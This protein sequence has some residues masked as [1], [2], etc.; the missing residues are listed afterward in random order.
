MLDVSDLKTFDNYSVENE[1]YDISKLGIIDSDE[2]FDQTLA[3]NAFEKL[4][5]IVSNL[6]HNDEI[7]TMMKLK[8]EG[9]LRICFRFVSFF[10]K[11]MKN[12]EML[13]II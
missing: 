3:E 12:E 5:T 9:L 4:E 8:D 13:D 6:L 1:D 11:E 10:E 7:K 2:E